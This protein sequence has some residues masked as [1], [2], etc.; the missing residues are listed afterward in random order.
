VASLGM[1][2]LPVVIVPHPIGGL[3]PDEVRAKADLILKDI[4]TRLLK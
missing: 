1:P 4:I 3:K 2:S